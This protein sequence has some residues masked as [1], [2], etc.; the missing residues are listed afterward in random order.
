[1]LPQEIDLVIYHRKCIDGF[2]SALAI[3][4]FHEINRNDGDPIKDIE[5]ISANHNNYTMPNVTGRNVL[6]CDFSYTYDETM[7]IISQA[8]QVLIIDHHATAQDNLKN[9][10]DK[11]K[12]FDMTHSAAVLTWK[13]A[14]PELS[15]PLLMQYIEDRDLSKNSME[16][17][18]EFFVWFS[19]IPQVFDM[20]QKYL[21][22]SLLSKMI[23]NYGI[24]Y[25][26]LNSYYVNG[27][28]EHAKASFT[29][30]QVGTNINYYFVGYHNQT[31][32]KSDVGNAIM[33]RYKNL[34][35]S[36][37][38]SLSD[39]LAKSKFALRSNNMSLDVSKVAALFGGGGHRNAAGLVFS[40]ITN[41]LIKEDNDKKIYVKTVSANPN[42]Y[43]NLVNITLTTI[44]NYNIM[45]LNTFACYKELA[46]YL[47][48]VREG[49]SNLQ[50]ALFIYNNTNGTTHN[51]KVDMVITYYYDNMNNMRVHFVSDLAKTLAMNLKNQVC[52]II[53]GGN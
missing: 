34:D 40:F 27:S 45:Y 4:L 25:Y 37:V 44:R 51:F 26:K 28:A 7:Q 21:D 41:K 31:N 12:I 36:A 10:P 9:V 23:H 49:D 5:Y 52:N 18:N 16:F 33:T 38:Y 14:F 50:Q 47:M 17:T 35:F 2:A 29:S 6:I 3:H 19:T 46:Q 43:S 1:M 32:F 22:N 39:N 42:L 15:V 11:Y 8:N 53:C 20:Y 48:Q 13:Y 30:I 24:V